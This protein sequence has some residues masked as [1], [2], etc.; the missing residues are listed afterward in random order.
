[1]CK[2]RLPRRTIAIAGLLVVGIL[3]RIPFRSTILHHWDSVNFA[4]ALEQFDIAV[5]QP[6]PPGYI[7]YVMVGRLLNSYIGDANASLV[8]IS[9]IASGIAV[10]L[11]Y[12]LAESI[13]DHSTGLVSAGLMLCSPLVWF[14]GEVALSYMVEGLFVLAV[15][16]Q[17]YAQRTGHEKSVWLSA[18]LLGIAGGFRQNTLVFLFPLWFAAIWGLGLRKATLAVGILAATVMSWLVPMVALSGGIDRY[19]QAVSATGEA[20][21]SESSLLDPAQMLANGLRLG[22]YTCYAL[23]VGAVPLAF[24]A[25][26]WLKRRLRRPLQF[27]VDPREWLFFWWLAP[28]LL[29]YTF[30]H[31]RQAGHSMTFVPALLVLASAAVQ[32][33]GKRLTEMTQLRV[34]GGGLVCFVLLVNCVFFLAAPPKLFGSSRI[35]FSSPSRRSIQSQ[36][37]YVFE[38][39]SAIRANFDPATTAVLASGRSF[40]YPDYY[41]HDYRYP[42]LSYTLGTERLELEGVSTIVLF[43][44]SLRDLDS[45]PPGLQ[46]I[47]LPGNASL[48]YLACNSESIWVDSKH[49]VC[50]ASDN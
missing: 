23:T 25:Q 29:F 38:R 13:W 37:A 24:A 50:Q 44:E 1:M 42:S 46:S 16:K 32:R 9:C 48:S 28:S 33:V 26:A 36:D 35:L 21:V 4:L 47:A 18:L 5:H 10:A 19:W 22:V 49:L 27:G 41:L 6:Q 20:L 17:C 14:H 12:S 11:A 3:T 34:F 2:G 39:I 15:A 31:I 43:D 7:L 8:W 40:R 30:G 45:D